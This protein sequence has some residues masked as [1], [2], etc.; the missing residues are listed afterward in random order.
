MVPTATIVKRMRYEDLYRYT[1]AD[2]MHRLHT[3]EIPLRMLTVD[4]LEFTRGSDQEHLD[5]IACGTVLMRFTEN[6]IFHK[7]DRSMVNRAYTAA[8]RAQF[9]G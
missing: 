8:S 4:P 7:V 9:S 5:I 6:E 3:V 1:I 2:D